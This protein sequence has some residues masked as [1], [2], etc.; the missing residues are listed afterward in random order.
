M[1]VRLWKAI[2]YRV[3]SL[4]MLLL[5]GARQEN[6]RG[7]STVEERIW[8]SDITREESGAMR[9]GMRLWKIADKHVSVVRQAFTG[10]H[11][12]KIK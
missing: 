3:I 4:A 7:L 12:L 1:K 8:R 6:Q 10:K 2:P 9:V 11:K 5:G